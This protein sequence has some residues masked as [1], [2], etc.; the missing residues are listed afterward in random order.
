MVSRSLEIFKLTKE[1]LMPNTENYNEELPTFAKLSDKEI[2]RR[3]CSGCSDSG[4]GF[5]PMRQMWVCNKCKR[6]NY[7][8]AGVTEE[9]DCC[10]R[11]YVVKKIP[12]N[13][14]L[15]EDCNQ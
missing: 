3:T 9:C 14:L 10:Y 4:W 5:D 12:D 13:N 6:P 7:L 15:C 8:A 2:W 11:R 1:E